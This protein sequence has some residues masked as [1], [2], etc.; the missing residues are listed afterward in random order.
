MLIVTLTPISD[1]YRWSS[2][3]AHARG[4]DSQL[5]APHLQYLQLGGKKI[6]R[7]KAYREL[8][9]DVLTA[10]QID[11]IRD[12]LEKGHALGNDRFRAEMERL[13]GIRQHSVKPGPKPSAKTGPGSGEDNLKL[14][15]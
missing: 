6:Q 10:E 14:L 12:S 5:W 9:S 3:H 4:I 8:F 11:R 2:Y 13:T 15:L 7:I 1:D